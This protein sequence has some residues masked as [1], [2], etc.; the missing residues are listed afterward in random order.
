MLM[1]ATAATLAPCILFIEI[2]EW[3]TRSEWPGLTLA[4]GLSL[5]GVVHAG[6]ES[7]AQRFAD[8]L[9]ATPLA[10]ASFA[11]GICLFLTA[12]SLGKWD[13]ERELVLELRE[14]SPFHWL[15]IWGAADVS[16]R[17]AFRLLF[18]DSLLVFLLWTAGACIAAEGLLSLFGLQP[19][20]LALSG[21]II[22]AAG[23]GARMAL[24]RKL[25]T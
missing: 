10:V 20:W 3:L 13:R 23:L 7:E 9:L 4:D 8:V 6:A 2:F 18:L 19:R 25:P 16:Y 12:L 11:T 5:F 14:K 24:Q 21:L 15:T 22:L 1:G 17:S